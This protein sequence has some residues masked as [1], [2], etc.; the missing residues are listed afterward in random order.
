[1]KHFR[2]TEVIRPNIKAGG[3]ENVTV[4]PTNHQPDESMNQIHTGGKA[5]TQGVPR[6]P[7]PVDKYHI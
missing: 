2:A 4:R 7:P 6:R 5:Q 1:M 3:K